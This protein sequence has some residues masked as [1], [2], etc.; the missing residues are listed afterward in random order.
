M[1]WLFINRLRRYLSYDFQGKLK[2]LASWEIQPVS[3]RIHY[4]LIL[5]DFPYIPVA[6]LTKLWQ[7]GYLFIEKIDK[8][9]VGR[10]GSYIAKYLTKD[11]EKYAVQLH[12]IKRFFKSQNLK[13]INEKYYLINREAFEKI[14]PLV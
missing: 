3:K 6:K 1:F 4:H 12:K 13:G 8:V 2:Y 5:F 14:A 9:D 10:R 7:N 11:I